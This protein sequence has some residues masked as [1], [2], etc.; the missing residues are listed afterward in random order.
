M[1]WKVLLL[2][3]SLF[4]LP[5]H[6]Y[7]STYE[8]GLDKPYVNIG[9]VPWESIKAGDQVLIHWRP[10]PYVEKW[11]IAVQGT[12][13]Q[14]FLVSGVANGNGQL[15]IIDGNGAITRNSINF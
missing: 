9:D 1:R 8:V 4:C 5:L 10:E 2:W 6:A 3:F 15:P 12:Q 7:S 14:P 13:Q 11:V